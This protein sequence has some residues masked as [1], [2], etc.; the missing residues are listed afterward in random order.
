MDPVRNSLNLFLNISLNSPPHSVVIFEI[1]DYRNARQVF[2]H[3]L[4]SKLE[5]HLCYPAEGVLGLYTSKVDSVKFIDVGF[6]LDR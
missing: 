6:F 4:S 5:S 2:R 1:P 3:P